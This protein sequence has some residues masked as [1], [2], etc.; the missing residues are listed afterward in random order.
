MKE[1]P[2]KICVQFTNAEVDRMLT[3]AENAERER[4]SLR[5]K[6]NALDK[7]E[8]WLREGKDFDGAAHRMTAQRSSDPRQLLVRLEVGPFGHGACKWYGKTYKFYEAILGAIEAAAK[9]PDAES[10]SGKS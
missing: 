6:A 1:D 5:E 7:L 10:D 9:E 3:R 8:A 2:D 4:D